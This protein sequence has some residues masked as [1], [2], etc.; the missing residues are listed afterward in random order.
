MQEP[1]QE[2]GIQEL[3]RSGAGV[4]LLSEDNLAGGVKASREGRGRVEAR[5]S[6]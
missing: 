6:S 2:D 4:Q 5:I 1:G 3:E